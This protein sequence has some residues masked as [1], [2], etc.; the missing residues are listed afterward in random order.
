MSEP[1]DTVVAYSRPKEAAL[2]FSHVIPIT[3]FQIA[4][5]MTRAYEESLGGN[6]A[7][8]AEIMMDELQ[9]PRGEE[10]LAQLLPTA[11]RSDK[12][13]T[14]LLAKV[15]IWLYLQNLVGALSP[16]LDD[17]QKAQRFTSEIGKALNVNLMDETSLDASIETLY[18]RYNLDSYPVIL[19][20]D[21]DLATEDSEPSDNADDFRVCMINAKLIDTADASW[22]QIISLREDVESREKLQRLRR[23]MSTNY[24]GKSRSFVEDDLHQRI[25]DHEFAVKKFGF[26]T[27]MTV[28]EAVFKSK[29]LLATITGAT[30]AAETGHPLTAFASLLAGVSLEVGGVAIQLKKQRYEYDEHNIRHP[31]GYVISAKEHLKS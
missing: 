11:L 7:V 17:P 18:E 9:L 2:Y 22:D 27:T 14:K 13:F 16:K 5:G 6:P 8:L 20:P 10:G 28:L 3:Y 31:M 1:A 4:S 30:V 19:L 15:P 26:N 12:V 23:F 29:T 21:H 24:E 25:E